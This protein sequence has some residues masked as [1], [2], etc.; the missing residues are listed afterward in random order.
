MISKKEKGIIYKKKMVKANIFNDLMMLGD[1]YGFKP[2][3]Q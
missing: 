1:I 3:E 2:K